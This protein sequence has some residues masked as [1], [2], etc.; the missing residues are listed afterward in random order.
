[1]LQVIILSF[2]MGNLAIVPFFELNVGWWGVAI[3]GVLLIM[4]LW[5]GAYYL[6]KEIELRFSI[7]SSRKGNEHKAKLKQ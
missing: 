1:M 5:M 4:T 3:Y 6:E 2:L 7:A